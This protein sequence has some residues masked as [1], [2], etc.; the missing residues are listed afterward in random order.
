MWWA[1]LD[2]NQGPDGMRRPTSVAEF[3]AIV[4]RPTALR[5][6]THRA[7]RAT[8]IDAVRTDAEAVGRAGDEVDHLTG[9][10][11]CTIESLP[12]AITSAALMA[13]NAMVAVG[14]DTGSTLSVPRCG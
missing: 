12:G 4:E 1:H 8:G 10:R 3:G 5:A 2:S 13:N 6:T 9:K 7:W 11:V 14:L